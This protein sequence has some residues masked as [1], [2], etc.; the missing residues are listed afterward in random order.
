MNTEIFW[1]N[2]QLEHV[3]N[4][5]FIQ[6]IMHIKIATTIIL[7]LFLG[8]RASSQESENV[9][10]GHWNTLYLS[11]GG[12]GVLYSVNFD[13]AWY[14]GKSRMSV[15]IGGSYI[16]VIEPDNPSSTLVAKF[17]FP[18]QWNWFHGKRSTMEHGLGLS[19]LSG[20][21]AVGDA[22]GTDR[23]HS[24]SL[25][26]FLKP[27]GYR[28]QPK[29]NGVFIRAYSLIAFK[30]VEFNPSWSRLLV[31][32]PNYDYTIFPWFGLDVGYSFKVRK[33]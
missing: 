32:H 28:Y 10:A 4:A 20:W 7:V 25:T 13:R 24:T 12:Q 23:A 22:D 9:N 16:P 8:L 18:V 14:T 33:K 6:T 11:A 1:T 5:E 21:N 2:T 29:G 17:S 19:V 3:H 26:A 27:I 15:S 31:S 30:L